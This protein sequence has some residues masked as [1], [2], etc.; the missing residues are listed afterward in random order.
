M[1][2]T[3]HNDP[4]THQMETFRRSQLRSTVGLPLPGLDLFCQ[5]PET[6]HIVRLIVINADRQNIITRS[7]LSGEQWLYHGRWGC[8]ESCCCYDAHATYEKIHGE[9]TREI[10]K[11]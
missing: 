6:K 2:V 7:T 5:Q 1:R 8:L 4:F 10:N 9:S 11:K 3:K